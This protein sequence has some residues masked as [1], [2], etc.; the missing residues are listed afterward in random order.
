MRLEKWFLPEGFYSPQ[1]YSLQ[2][3]QDSQEHQYILSAPVKRC[4]HQKNLYVDLGA[5]YGIIPRSECVAPFLS[6][7]DREIA[8]ISCVGRNVSFCVI[9]QKTA[10][11]GDTYFILSRKAAQEK[12]VVCMEK[13]LA[14]G[15]ILPAQIT[16]L[17]YFG[18]FV[19]IGCGIIALLPLANISISRIKHPSER[20]QAGQRIYVIIDQIDYQAHRFYLTHRELLGTWME[21]VSHFSP[22]ETVPGIVRGCMDYGVF[23][24]LTPNLSGLAECG[25]P[26][27]NGT[28]V[29]VYIKSIQPQRAKV[30]LQIVQVLGRASFPTPL[31]YYITDG[32]LQNWQYAAGT[33][34]HHNTDKTFSLS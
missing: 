12:A 30:K 4:D 9:A 34:T 32:Q 23:I 31:T 18:A 14:P 33:D 19:D 11:N 25:E 8:I 24:E 26:L 20:F 6:G 5:F 15:C 16:H 22:G 27:T 3:L 29:S 2:Q 10:P 7:A 17:A 13:T 28:K 1:H 21:N